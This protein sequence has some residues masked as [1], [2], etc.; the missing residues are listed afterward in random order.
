VT[1]ELVSAVLAAAEGTTFI[2]AISPR[3]DIKSRIYEAVEV[4]LGRTVR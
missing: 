2:W 4:V 1:P 3:G